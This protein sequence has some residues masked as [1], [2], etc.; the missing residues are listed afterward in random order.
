MAT[1][2]RLKNPCGPSALNMGGVA[3]ETEPQPKLQPARV[4]HQYSL[5]GLRATKKDSP[6]MPKALPRERVASGKISVG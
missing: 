5:R 6:T 4:D 3:K 2:A 1:A